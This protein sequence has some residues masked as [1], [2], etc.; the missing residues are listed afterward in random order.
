M[1]TNIIPKFDTPWK[2]LIEILEFHKKETLEIEIE[3]KRY[4]LRTKYF[5]PEMRFV[6]DKDNEALG[7]IIRIGSYDPSDLTVL[8]LCKYGIS[9]VYSTYHTEN[10]TKDSFKIEYENNILITIDVLD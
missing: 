8:D 7:D 9:E 2:Q 4:S 1:A 6:D 3:V 10:F 5:I